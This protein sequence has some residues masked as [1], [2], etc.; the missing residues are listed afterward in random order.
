MRTAAVITVSDKCTAGLRHDESGPAITALLTEAG[1]GVISQKTVPDEERD[2]MEALLEAAEAGISLIL[3]TGGTGFAPRDRTPEAT[4]AVCERMVPGIPEAMRAESLKITHRAMLSRA[5]CG[6][7]GRS[8][9]LNLPG[10][11][12]AARENLSA[13]L[14]TLGHG[15]DIL[16]ETAKECAAPKAR[17]LSV[18]ISPRKGEAKTPIPTGTL[19][20]DHGLEGDAHAGTSAHR[21]V[22][23]L[24]I[25]SVKSL[26][27]SLPDLPP[28]AFAEN[29]LTEGIELH[30]LP[31]GTGLQIG[32]TICE[33]TQIGK[34]CHD[35]GCA[36]RQAVG[37][38]VMPRE[39]IFLRVLSDGTI[40]AGDE[41]RVL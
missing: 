41:I 20:R 8:L 19:R 31:I 14:D 5:V 15:L 3:T 30:T 37:D 17:V 2:V 35:T 6:I 21:Q 39:G 38:C 32:T 12:K 23:L 33:V 10:S 13:V 26:H 34:E 7:R 24:S 9:I 25:E 27:D 18:H 29:I 36:I 28:G 11:P 40:K 4:I 1:Y 16:A 22:S